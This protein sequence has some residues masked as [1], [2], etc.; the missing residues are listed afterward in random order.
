MSNA[1]NLT[2]NIISY[3]AHHPNSSPAEIFR[4]A[5]GRPAETTVDRFRVLTRLY[6][7]P[8][9]LTHLGDT[10]KA[11]EGRIFSDVDPPL[12][13]DNISFALINH[14]SPFWQQGTA[15]CYSSTPILADR[16]ITH[17]E[18]YPLSVWSP[19]PPW[20]GVIAF[21]GGWVSFQ[22]TGATLDIGNRTSDVRL[23]NFHLFSGRHDDGRAPELRM[24]NP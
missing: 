14:E 11:W 2:V 5:D 19:Q 7:E 22:Q 21:A 18:D 16:N 24:I 10:R 12:T 20:T 23:T 9:P 4:L 8:I 13:A 1:R 6:E 17:D 3:M 15:D